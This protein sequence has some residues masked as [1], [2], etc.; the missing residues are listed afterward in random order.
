MS[1]LHIYAHTLIDGVSEQPKH[2]KLIT[3]EDSIITNIEDYHEIN[4]EAIEVNTLTP[5]FFNCHVHIFFL[6]VLIRRKNLL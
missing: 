3:I 2:E 1:K 5:G 6:L 4:E